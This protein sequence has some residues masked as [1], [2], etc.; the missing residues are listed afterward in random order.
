MANTAFAIASKT[1][2]YLGKGVPSSLGAGG[3]AKPMTCHDCQSH[4]RQASLLRSFFRTIGEQIPQSIKGLPYGLHKK[5]A[6]GAPLTS[7]PIPFNP[8]YASAKNTT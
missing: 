7:Q 2:A 1:L 5:D 6:G 8:S 4:S 3:F